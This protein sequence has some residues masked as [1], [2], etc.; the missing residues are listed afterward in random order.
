MISGAPAST[1]PGSTFYLL[2]K[3]VAM[4]TGYRQ[5]SIRSRTRM[6]G[7]GL[8]LNG[9]RPS[10]VIAGAVSLGEN[11]DFGGRPDWS[12]DGRARALPRGPSAQCRAVDAARSLLRKHSSRKHRTSSPSGLATVQN[13]GRGK[14]GP[15]PPK[16][17]PTSGMLVFGRMLTCSRLLL[18]TVF[19]GL[20]GRSAAG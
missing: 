12:N 15:V 8:V 5:V 6:L 11:P 16:T 10:N 9:S 14:P 2:A 17:R 13:S 1:W 3:T 7:V 20:E 19:A 4:A 18:T